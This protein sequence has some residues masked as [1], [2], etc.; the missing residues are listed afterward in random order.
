M[1]EEQAKRAYVENIFN[2]GELDRAALGHIAQ[3]HGRNLLIITSDSD[4]RFWVSSLTDIARE[5]GLDPG[6]TLFI[7]HHDNH[8]ETIIPR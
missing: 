7:Y 1:T 4:E 6:R 3:R 2:G 5:A 8:F